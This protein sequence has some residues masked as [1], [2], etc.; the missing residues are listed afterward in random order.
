[1]CS[2]QM[3]YKNSAAWRP[4]FSVLQSITCLA[5]NGKTKKS[6]ARSSVKL[7]WNEVLRYRSEDTGILQT[8]HRKILETRHHMILASWRRVRGREQETVQPLIWTSMRS[9]TFVQKYLPFVIISQNKKKSQKTHFRLRIIN[10]T[11]IYNTGKETFQPCE[12]GAALLFDGRRATWNQFLFVL[13]ATKFRGQVRTLTI[14]SHVENFNLMQEVICQ[15]SCTTMFVE[16][17]QTL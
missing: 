2:Y 17:D 12:A 11:Q 10:Y 3:E 9:D 1:M 5:M 13:L 6:L 7:P 14:F 4:T 16:I 8:R 15:E